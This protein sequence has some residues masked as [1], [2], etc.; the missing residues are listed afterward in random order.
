MMNFSS[1]IPPIFGKCDTLIAMVKEI[2]D[3]VHSPLQPEPLICLVPELCYMTG[4]TD[5]DR[6][7]FRVMKV[8]VL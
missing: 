7:D 8:S 2:V 3:C 6:A 1:F 4:L 5:S